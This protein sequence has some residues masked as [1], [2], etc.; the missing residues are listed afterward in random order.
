M[1]YDQ[2]IDKEWDRQAQHEL[3]VHPVPPKCLFGNIANFLV[4]GLGNELQ[5]MKDTGT[6]DRLKEQ[7]INK[8]ALKTSMKAHCVA[9]GRLCTPE[10]GAMLHVAGTPCTADSPMGLQERQ[11][12]LPFCFFLVW[13]AMRVALGEP[14]VIQ[15]CVDQFDRSIFTEVLGAWDWT[16]VV[17][18]PIQFGWPIARNRQWAVCLVGGYVMFVGPP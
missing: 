16:F 17:L 1:V 15:E 11:K 3:Q 7:V 14:I 5:H 6:I 18:S 4:P 8:R 9:H 13:A 10:E 12:S 2:R